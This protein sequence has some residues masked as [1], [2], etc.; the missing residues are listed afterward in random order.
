MKRF[1]AVLFVTCVLVGGL[2]YAMPRD[3]CNYVG[4]ISS[5]GIVCVYCKQ[6]S[7]GGCDVGFFR[8]VQCSAD[9]LSRVLMD[10]NDVDGVSVSFEG[11]QT[12][13]ERVTAL[14]DTTTIERYE[15][16]DVTVICGFSDKLKGCVVLD[17]KRV[18]VQISYC[19]GTVTVG[20]PLILGS[21]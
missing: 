2:L 7:L 8:I 1:F 6:T 11:T 12:D 14:L 9:Q 20:S 13:V 17:G 15:L 5:S 18:N 4:K 16:G 10:C 3:F 21:Y 19:R